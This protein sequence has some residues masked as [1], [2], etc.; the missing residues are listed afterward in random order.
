VGLAFV[1]ALVLRLGLVLSQGIDAPPKF[2]AQPD[3]IDYE[4]LAWSMSTGAGYSTAPGHP[5]AGRPPGTS[6]TLLPVYFV[7][8]HSFAAGRLWFCLLSA[9]TCVCAAWLASQCFGAQ[10]GVIAAFWLAVYPGHLYYPLHFVSEVPYALWLTLACAVT[11][12]ALTGSTGTTRLALLAGAIWGLAVLT[13]P[14]VVLIV[15]IAVVLAVASRIDRTRLLSLASMVFA[16]GLVLAPWVVRNALVIGA[17]TLSTVGGA[18]FW[19]ANNERVLNDPDLRGLWIQPTDLPSGEYP[20]EGSELEKEHAAWTYGRQFLVR[21]WPGVPGLVAM[22]LG[23]L[24]S[25][26]EPTDNTAAYWAF[27]LAWLLTAPW[28]IAGLF[29][30]LRDRGLAAAV[31]LTPLLATLA[32]AVVF[33]GSIRFRDSVIPLLVVL[34]A[35]AMPEFAAPLRRPLAAGPVGE[36]LAL[37]LHN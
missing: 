15:P 16:C 35:R 24:I 29:L 5:T 30:V 34:A 26:F 19:G 28:T 21:H 12:R 2:S 22:K 8:G 33:Y 23:R 14:Q 18:T 27:A 25:P 9:L 1:L 17:P 3:Q 20:L 13:R 37:P 10:A 7:F 4:R 11:M 31:L 36:R 32:T 6:L